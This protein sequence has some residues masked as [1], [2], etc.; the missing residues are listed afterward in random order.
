MQK[1]DIACPRLNWAEGVPLR[2][3][4]DLAA[5]AATRAEKQGQQY[6]AAKLFHSHRAND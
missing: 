4:H 5:D 1:D 2:T 6:Y 3:V